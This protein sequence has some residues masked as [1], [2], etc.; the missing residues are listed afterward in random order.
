[1]YFLFKAIHGIIDIHVEPY[2]RYA[3][4]NVLKYAYFHRVVGTWNSLLLS[5][6]EAKSVNSFKALVKKFFMD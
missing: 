5:F 4:T 6:R 3:R 2:V 1:M